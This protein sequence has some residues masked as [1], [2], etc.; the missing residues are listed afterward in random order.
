MGILTRSNLAG[1]HDVLAFSDLHKGNEVR[2]WK[3]DHI[4]ND[5]GNSDTKDDPITPSI[6]AKQK[7]NMGVFLRRCLS[8]KVLLR[9]FGIFSILHLGRRQRRN[10]EIHWLFIG[11]ECLFW[12]LDSNMK[13]N[14]EVSSQ[15]SDN[16]LVGGNSG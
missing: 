8:T 15:S 9:D 11:S 16:Q 12:V 4:K 3:L 13:T 10:L 6:A 7:R 2:L 14:I 1:Y 5:S